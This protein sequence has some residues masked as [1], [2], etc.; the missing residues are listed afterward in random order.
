MSRSRKKNSFLGIA[1]YKSSSMQKWKKRCNRI[2]R[3]IDIEEDIGNSSYIRKVN[4]RWT[5][6]MT[7]NI[8]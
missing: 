8:I 1:A 7:E 3:R 4:E 5:A 2:I 6:R